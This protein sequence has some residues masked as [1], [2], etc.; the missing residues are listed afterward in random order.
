MEGKLWRYQRIKYPVDSKWTDSNLREANAVAHPYFRVVTAGQRS[1]ETEIP[2]HLPARPLRLT[3]KKTSLG[4]IQS[5]KA[6]LPSRYAWKMQGIRKYFPDTIR[7]DWRTGLKKAGSWS[8]KRESVRI[9]IS[10]DALHA[11]GFIRKKSKAPGSAISRM[12]GGALYARQGRH[13]LNKWDKSV[14]SVYRGEVW[15]EQGIIEG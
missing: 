6:I 7:Q 12:T 14:Y 10:G 15:E 2:L 4:H 11:N 9:S 8:S 13:H 1:R 3:R 5:K